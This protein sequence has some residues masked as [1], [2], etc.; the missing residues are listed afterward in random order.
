MNF[1]SLIRDRYN[2]E[3]RLMPALLVSLPALLAVFVWFPSLR[4]A[5]PTLLAVLGF[6][7]VTVWIAHLARSL[8]TTLQPKLFTAWGGQPTVAALRHRDALLPT[9]LKARYHAFLRKA[10]H[11]LALPSAEE[12]KRDEPAADRAYEAG[13]AWLLAQTR[14]KKNFALLFEENVNYGFRRN[15]LAMKPIALLVAIT[16][17]AI[18]GTLIFRMINAGQQPSVEVAATAII[19]TIYIALV[20][21]LVRRDWVRSAATA[22]ARQLLAA[23]DVLPT[24]TS[25]TSPRS[26][27]KR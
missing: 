14:D 8:G 24:P 12:E 5:V 6:C 11:G 1:D 17:L 27:A 15:F 19:I 16:T 3:A 22:Y 7:G 23:C 20:S 9:E 13:C 2:R 25:P 4:T 26:R 10:V 18:C 21:I